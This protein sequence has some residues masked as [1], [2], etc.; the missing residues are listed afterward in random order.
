[1]KTSSIFGGTIGTP[2]ALEAKSVSDTGEFEGYGAVFDAVDDGGDSIAPGAFAKSLS[3]RAADRVKMLWQHDTHAPIGRW[4]DMAEDSRGLIVK[5][6]LFL[7]V[8]QGREAYEL[9]REGAVDGLSIGYRTKRSET[10]RSTGVRRLNE[11]DLFEVSV[12]TFPMMPEARISLVKASGEMATEREFEDWLARDAGFSRSQAK[13][14]TAHG[15]KA[16]KTARDAGEGDSTADEV[17][18]A[19]RRLAANMRR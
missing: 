19:I 5:G 10:E 14:I 9:V 2:I 1:M 12:V 13:V 16:L 17:A 6:K 7:N 11:V 3:E 15:Y 18:D 4:L 8:Q